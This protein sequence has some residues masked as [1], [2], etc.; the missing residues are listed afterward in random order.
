MT[1]PK[2]FLGFNEG[3]RRVGETHHNAGLS[4]HE[5][6]LL[7]LLLDERENLIETLD[8]EGA[9]QHEIDAKLAAT[10][11]SYRRLAEKFEVSKSTVQ[12][13]NQGRQRLQK[14]VRLVPYP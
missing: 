4:D 6:G 13:I 14:P 11:L 3:G 7:L 12:H 1:R 8:A 10:G 2:K 9:V 5:V